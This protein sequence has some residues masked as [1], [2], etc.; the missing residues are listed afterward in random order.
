MNPFIGQIILFGGNF[1]PLGWSLC[2]GQLISIAS[3]SALFSILGTTCGGDGVS[4]FGLP[5]LRSRVPLQAGAGPGLSTYILGVKGGTASVTLT[6]SQMP[7]HHHTLAASAEPASSSDPTGAVPAKSAGL[8]GE[9]LIYGSTP[10]TTM[11]SSAIQN[12]GESQS[13]ENRQPTIAM[14]YIIAMVGVYPSRS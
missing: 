9:T 7:S 4:T 6:S 14:N 2:H 10:S 8:S 1:A 13:H 11:S 12:A 3:N 5:D